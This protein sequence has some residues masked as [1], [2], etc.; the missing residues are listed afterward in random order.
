MPSIDYAIPSRRDFSTHELILAV[1]KGPA[2]HPLT[3]KLSSR[4]RP[5]TRP[6]PARAHA[7]E[8]D[9]YTRSGVAPPPPCSDIVIFSWWEES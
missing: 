1:L 3:E 5:P 7:H 6:R 4:D 2:S 8:A 9:G